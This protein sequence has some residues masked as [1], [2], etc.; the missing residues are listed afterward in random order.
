MTVRSWGDVPPGMPVHHH[1][2]A[3]IELHHDPKYWTDASSTRPGHVAWTSGEVVEW[4][5]STL[6]QHLPEATGEH[7]QWIEEALDHEA[8]RWARLANSARTGRWM[9]DTF[10][11]STGRKLV[12]QVLG[13]ADAGAPARGDYQVCSQHRRPADHAYEGLTAEQTEHFGRYGLLPA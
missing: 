7:R 1:C 9:M 2:L 6:K 5:H 8:P 13:Y 3:T 11:L 4:V 10:Q 12:F